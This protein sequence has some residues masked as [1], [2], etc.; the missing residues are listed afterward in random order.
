MILLLFEPGKVKL[1]KHSQTNIRM[2]LVAVWRFLRTGKTIIDISSPSMHIA[3]R[4]QVADIPLQV[5]IRAWP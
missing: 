5:T 4:Y 2:G 1:L 3:C